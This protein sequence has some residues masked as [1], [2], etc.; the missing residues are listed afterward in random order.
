MS[1]AQGGS[2]SPSPGGFF[3]RR[4]KPS[5]SF[6]ANQLANTSQSY[7]FVKK[8]PKAVPSPENPVERL[9]G[10]VGIRQP[11]SETT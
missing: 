10:T 5:E 1:H 7:L 3:R 2:S 11:G 9:L 8:D 6:N 4:Q